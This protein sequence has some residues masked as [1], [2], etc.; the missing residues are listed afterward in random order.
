[1]DIKDDK[2]HINKIRKNYNIFKYSIDIVININ[3]SE[4]TL[5]YLKFINNNIIKYKSNKYIIAE[6][7]DLLRLINYSNNQTYIIDYI[8]KIY[9]FKYSKSFF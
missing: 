4:I 8:A 2:N 3:E 7:M 5:E 9:S 1:M 6:H